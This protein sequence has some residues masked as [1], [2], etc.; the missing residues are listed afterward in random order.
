MYMH[1]VVHLVSAKISSFEFKT[2]FLF[3]NV[4]ELSSSETNLSAGN[5]TVPKK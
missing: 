4:L 3:V 1:Q 5:S 2:I